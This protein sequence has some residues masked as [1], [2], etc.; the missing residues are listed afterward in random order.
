M[1]KNTKITLIALIAIVAL[2]FIATQFNNKK[3]LEYNKNDQSNSIVNNTNNNI[4]TQNTTMTP[5]TKNLSLVSKTWQWYATETTGG[6]G[7]MPKKLNAFN[8]TFNKDGTFNSTTD[9]NNLFGKYKASENG[10]LVF[11]DI[12]STRMGCPNAQE[13]MYVDN[14]NNVVSFEF[15]EYDN[16]ILNI[17]KPI[18]IMQFK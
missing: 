13:G 4:P 10:D 3:Q 7:Y 17:A 2:M 12:A 8:L 9:C 14:L 11:S 18:G 6:K 5:S 15:D 16:L 1:T